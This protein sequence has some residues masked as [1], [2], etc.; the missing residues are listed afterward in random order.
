RAGATLQLVQVM[1][2]LGSIYTETPLFVDSSFEQEVRE[3]ER[4][5]SLAYLERTVKKLNK[6]SPVRAQTVLLEGDI[7]NLL[8]QQATRARADLVVMTTHA[9]GP[10]G[11]FWLGSVAD[12]LV[13][14]L[15]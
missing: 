13:R 1:P 15:P 12:E 5:K 8:R 4:A 6:V 11:R 3:H 2:P 14:K 7:P 10:L 9:R